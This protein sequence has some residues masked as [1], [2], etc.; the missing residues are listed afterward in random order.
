MP[1]P[2]QQRILDVA[3]QR[4][5]IRYLM[6]PRDPEGRQGLDCSLFVCLTFRDAGFPF[7]GAV[8]TAEQ[9]RQASQQ[10]DRSEMQTGDLLFFENTYD[11]TGQR[12]PDGKIAT[13]V[14]IAI[15]GSG[16]QMWDCHASNDNTDLPG[17]G[18]TS[19]NEYYWA[20]KLFDVR[21]AP[22]LPDS[23]E[24]IRIPL[25]DPSAARFRVTADGLRL[26]AAPSTS[27]PILVDDL[28]EGI[29]LTAVDDQVVEG[30]GHQWRHLRTLEGMVGWAAAS[31]LEHVD[32]PVVPPPPPPP[33]RFRIISDALRLRDQPGLVSTTLDSLTRD[34]VVTAVEEATVEADEI[35]WRHVRTDGGVVGWMSSRFLEPVSEGGPSPAAATRRRSDVKPGA[36]RPRRSGSGAK[37]RRRRTRGEGRSPGASG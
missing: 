20:P 26:R 10:I 22:G 37:T 34:A 28:G 12:G 11:A 3:A 25:P 29:L 19:I 32:G 18:I 33:S 2:E 36:R 23:G 17:V 14:G 5:G 31:F 4:Q 27:A 13:H 30:D 16:Q 6:P 35:V 21:R 24:F 7:A 9:L 8:R 15:D 1:T